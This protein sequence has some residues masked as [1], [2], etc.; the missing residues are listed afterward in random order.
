M[1]AGLEH[2]TDRIEQFLANIW[3]F[4]PETFAASLL[5]HIIQA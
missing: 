4:T 2:F 1:D 5:R 3:R